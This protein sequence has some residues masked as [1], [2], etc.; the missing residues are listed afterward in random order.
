MQ[1]FHTQT[2]QV[3]ILTIG[4]QENNNKKKLKSCYLSDK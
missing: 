2:R 1:Y 3:K 4:I